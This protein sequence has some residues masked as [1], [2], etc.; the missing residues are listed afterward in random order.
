MTAADRAMLDRP[1][2][3]PGWRFFLLAAALV[4][5]LAFIV[6]LVTDATRAWSGR[7]RSIA[8]KALRASV[9]IPLPQ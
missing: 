2:L 7:D 3:T 1:L 5:L 8:K 4:G 9:A 6:G